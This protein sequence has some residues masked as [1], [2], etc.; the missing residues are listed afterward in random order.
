M[1]VYKNKRL[2]N[3]QSDRKQLAPFF[4]AA[5]TILADPACKIFVCNRIETFRVAEIKILPLHDEKCCNAQYSIIPERRNKDEWSKCH[6]ISPGV[7]AA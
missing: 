1:I 6:K 7:Y 4:A 3:I 5:K 2:K